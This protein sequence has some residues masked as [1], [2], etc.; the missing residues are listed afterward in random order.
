MTY[1]RGSLPKVTVALFFIC[2]L[3]YL[4]IQNRLETGQFGRSPSS[5]SSRMLMN[6]PVASGSIENGNLRDTISN[7]GVISAI[8][9]MVHQIGAAGTELTET[10]VKDISQEIA[11]QIADYVVQRLSQ[12]S[13]SGSSCYGCWKHHN[14][15]GNLQRRECLSERMCTV[16][17][18]CLF[19]CVFPLADLPV[20]YLVTPTYRRPEQ[21]P[22][23]TRLA[24]TLLNV[25]AIHWI[26]VEDSNSLSPTV[27][28]LL[29]RYGIPHTHLKGKL[30]LC[31]FVSFY[32]TRFFEVSS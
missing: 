29:Q 31:I 8:D 27:S 20:V 5:F 28:A 22:D 24:Q 3:V 21:I 6:H 9:S 13:A 4:A 16:M 7:S 25:P 17:Y 18:V 30:Q 1:R 19:F 12:N 2:C 32:A 10:R 11:K 23:L 26:V 15:T 14:V